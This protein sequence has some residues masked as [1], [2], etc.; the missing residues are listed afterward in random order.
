MLVTVSISGQ[1]NHVEFAISRP[2]IQSTETV[3]KQ[4]VKAHSVCNVGMIYFLV[5]EHDKKQTKVYSL[6]PAR[7]NC[8][9]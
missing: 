4:C 9:M 8:T 1:T 5:L 7:T 2:W 6:P 3:K